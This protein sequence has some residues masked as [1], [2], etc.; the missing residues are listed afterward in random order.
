[1]MKPLTRSSAGK[2]PSVDHINFQDIKI[3]KIPRF[4]GG[5]D[6]VKNRSCNLNLNSDT[7]AWSALCRIY[8]SKDS[9]N[10]TDDDEEDDDGGFDRKASKMEKVTPDGGIRKKILHTSQRGAKKPPDVGWITVRLV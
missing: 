5:V 7:W 2:Q 4:I 6:V 1:M 10:T 9:A 8:G 3:H